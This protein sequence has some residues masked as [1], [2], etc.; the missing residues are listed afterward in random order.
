MRTSFLL[1]ISLCGMWSVSAMSQVGT[2]HTRIQGIDIPAIPNAPFAAKISVLW[3]EPLAGGGTVSRK[4]FTMVARDS[5]GRVHRET[6]GFVRGESDQE[7]PLRT[8]TLLDPT[9]GT[10]IV[11]TQATMSCASGAFHARLEPPDASGALAVTNMKNLN[12][13]D[14]GPR[15]MFGL[16]VTGTRETAL[17]TAGAHGSSRLALSQTE[18]WYSAD[19]HIPLSVIRKNPQTGQVTITV[20]DLTRAEPDRSWFVPPSGYEVKTAQ[21]K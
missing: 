1:G 6:R 10:R 2:V 16:T 3:E 7:P 20:T 4:Y 17:D 9:S 13:E 21:I 12:S 18:T 8:T 11:C 19:L 15:T 14:L 5:Q